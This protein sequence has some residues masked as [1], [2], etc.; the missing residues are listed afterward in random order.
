MTQH[1]SQQQAFD[2]LVELEKRGIISDFPELESG[3]RELRQIGAVP[4]DPFSL[5]DTSP[6]ELKDDAFIFET[7]PE[8][9]LQ[10]VRE[11]R[12]RA[13]VGIVEDPLSFKDNLKLGLSLN[14]KLEM[15]TILT[16][17]FG[18][19]VDVRFDRNTQKFQYLDPETNRITNAGREG[20]DLG[21]FGR[22]AG[23]APVVAGDVIGSVGGFI[24]GAAVTRT[25]TGA[26]A[27]E[28]TG[29]SL[30]TYI[31]ELTRLALGKTMGVNEDVSFEQMNDSALIKAGFA[32]AATAVTG[33]VINTGKSVFNFIN[34]RVFSK[35]AGLRSGLT[36]QE[37]DAAIA[38]VN[39]LLEGTGQTVKATTAKRAGDP[40][41]LGDEAV[42]RRETEF[43]R[44]FAERDKSDAQAL[45]TA[46]DEVSPVSEVGGQ[47]VTKKFAA[48][49]A[50]RIE[51]AETALEQSR[52]TLSDNL[53]AIGSSITGDTAASTRGAISEKRTVV[54][55]Q[56]KRVNGVWLKQAGANAEGTASQVQIPV[57]KQTRKLMSS[58]NQESRDA[59]VTVTRQDRSGVFTNQ[60]KD[61]DSVDLIDYQRAISDL[62]AT[63]RGADRNESVSKGQVT[64]MKRAVKALVKDR[65]NVLRQTGRDDLFFAIKSA[66]VFTRQSRDMLDRSIAGDLMVKSNN[67][68]KVKSKEVFDTAFVRGGKEESEQLM[69]VIGDNPE[70]VRAWRSEILSKYKNTVF[71]E[72][73]TTRASVKAHSKFIDDFSDSMAPFFSKPEMAQ[74]NKL[75]GMVKVVEKQEKAMT[76]ILSVLNKAGIPTGATGR[77]VAQT[78]KTLASLDPE[79]IAPW[80]ISGNKGPARARRLVRLLESEPRVLE[81][82]R[83]E[84]RLNM[85]NEIAPDGAIN[86]AAFDAHVRKNAAT[87]RDLFGEKY[88][89]DLFAINKVLKITQRK[90]AAVGPGESMQIPIQVARG[91]VARPLS[92]EGRLLTAGLLFKL[93]GSKRAIARALLNPDDLN[94]IAR[95]S[96]LNPATRQFSELAAS[97]GMLQLVE[98]GEQ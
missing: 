50:A 86:P 89:D 32:G 26:L 84:V 85:R 73:K 6:V 36:S 17:R 38:Q 78:R 66:D 71:P 11:R 1:V 97:L 7:S 28:A 29:A 48:D 45:L 87:Y 93:R 35:E 90:G 15:E 68:F 59:I 13:D 94:T 70:A 19:D 58:L 37:S 8:E 79:E 75:G 76:R 20:L 30:G 98:T 42:V 18:G 10:G 46:F 47:A 22:A 60:F 55:N 57:G 92:R 39:Q 62:R 69:A 74:I 52:Q 34:G 5:A 40:A 44:E 49:R 96:E 91:T 51:T 95:M 21:D 25:P 64:V 77:T 53:D 41:L 31:G 2:N 72:D 16:E 43:I 14:P 33:G 88:V 82:I 65:D 4:A 83:G 63:I 9:M 23:E 3:L 61:Q 24:T 12:A 27:A 80:V 67:R 54:N 56:V 81:S